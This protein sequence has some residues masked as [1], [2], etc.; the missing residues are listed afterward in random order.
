MYYYFCMG[1]CGNLAS[2]CTVKGALATIE[3]RNNVGI[4]VY[5]KLIT[6]IDIAFV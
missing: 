2:I 5:L 6:L 1:R 4:I 3:S